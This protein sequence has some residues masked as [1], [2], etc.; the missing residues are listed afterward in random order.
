LRTLLPRDSLFFELDN[1]NSNVK[2][3]LESLPDHLEYSIDVD[4]NPNGNYY[5]YQDFVDF[6]KSLDI[7]MD[8]EIPLSLKAN[9]LQLVDT[10]DFSLEGQT[11]FD[12]I[13]NID[14]NFIVD[15]SFPLSAK[16]QLYFLDQNGKIIDSLFT[17][18]VEVA[19]GIPVAPLCKV[20]DMVNSHFVS[21]FDDERT[22]KIKK[23]TKAV[24]KAYFNTNSTN[25]CNDYLKIYSDYKFDF[26]LTSRFK[27]RLFDQ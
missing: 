26:K 22:Q 10:I 9:N 1:S 16:T 4:I 19:S 8:I 21:E 14:F 11:G 5:N 27:Y 24:I 20:N 13:R 2:A 3:L 15:N 18:Y 23:T 12:N 17:D 6:E 25:N 7:S